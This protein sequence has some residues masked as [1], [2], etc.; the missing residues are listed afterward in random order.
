MPGRHPEG[1][2]AAAAARELQRHHR[3]RPLQGPQGPL[4]QRP[5]QQPAAA[6]ATGLSS[7]IAPPVVEPPRAFQRLGDLA[8]RRS[9]GPARRD[10]IECRQRDLAGRAPAD[11][12]GD[13]RRAPGELP[14]PFGDLAQ[15]G[16][17]GLAQVAEGRAA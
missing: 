11:R 16:R 10:R 8:G 13:A 15:D 9:A 17:P 1:P 4:G 6:A 7:V 2:F 3:P 12:P 14:A 5:G